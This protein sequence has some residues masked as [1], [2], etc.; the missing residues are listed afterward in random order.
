MQ[1]KRSDHG[2]KEIKARMNPCRNKQAKTSKSSM[3]DEGKDKTQIATSK[4]VGSACLVEDDEIL[5]QLPTRPEH[6]SAMIG[7]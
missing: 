6:T 1:T 4:Q 2:D 3:E 7:K 5:R